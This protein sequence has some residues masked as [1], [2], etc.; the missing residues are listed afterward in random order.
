MLNLT[1]LRIKPSFRFLLVALCLLSSGCLSNLERLERAPQAGTKFHQALAV[2]YL[3]FSRSEAEQ[4]D[5]ADSDFFAL[6]GLKAAR[7]ERVEPVLVDH[8]D[9]P[10]A[11]KVAAS[12]ARSSLL[13]LLS[14]D[15]IRHY[16]KVAA[17]AIFL[18]D[19]W[20]EQ[21]EEEWQGEHINF[22]REEFYVLLDYLAKNMTTS[23]PHP[24]TVE[25]ARQE[26]LREATEKK[27]KAKKDMLRLSSIPEHFAKTKLDPKRVFFESGST[28][29]DVEALQVVADVAESLRQIPRYEIILNAYSDRVGDPNYNLILS[30]KRAVIVKDALTKLGLDSTSITFYAFGEDR[31]RVP[32]PDNVPEHSNRFVEVNIS[33]L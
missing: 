5:W 18:F 17:K 11:E 27:E 4:Y 22:C 15:T 28:S 31:T 14:D 23:E 20:L 21:Q 9:I 8:W 24:L 26:Q 6:K 1:A 25:E 19:C 7:G 30:R 12:Q 3:D 2:D 29:L 33:I 13:E 32:T 10:D 16:P